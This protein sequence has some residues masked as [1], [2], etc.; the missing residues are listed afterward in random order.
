MA[1]YAL[2]NRGNPVTTIPHRL[3]YDEW[4]SRL[5]PLEIQAI[6]AEFDRIIRRRK[7]GEICTERLLS[8]DFNSMGRYD[9]EG[10]PFL[11][12]WDKACRLDRAHTC[13]CFALL[14]WEHMMNRPDA[15]HFEKLD[16]DNIP[17]AATRYHRCVRREPGPS[18][19][20]SATKLVGCFAQPTLLS[21]GA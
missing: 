19:G 2:G 13:W 9:W 11:K 1:L 12:I 20:V 6:N 18:D 14:L 21:S 7:S 17:M 16:L 5:E 8:T 10:S 3:L 15:W 4:R